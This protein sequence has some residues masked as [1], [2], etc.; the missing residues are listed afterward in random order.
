MFETFFLK[1]HISQT[2]LNNWFLAGLNSHISRS[3]TGIGWEFY[4]VVR[5]IITKLICQADLLS[6]QLLLFFLNCIDYNRN[7]ATN[8]KKMLYRQIW[9][10]CIKISSLEI[11]T[12]FINSHSNFICYIQNTDLNFKNMYFSQDWANFWVSQLLEAAHELS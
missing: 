7:S 2:T 5:D 4:Y 10:A 6:H 12:F 3:P 1:M 9:Y 11:G 8:S